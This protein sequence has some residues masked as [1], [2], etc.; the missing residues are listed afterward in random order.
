MLIPIV[1]QHFR[2]GQRPSLRGGARSW[3]SLDCELAAVHDTPVHC[4]GKLINQS[5]VA[6][7]FFSQRC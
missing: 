2:G 6:G 3:H 5:R 4:A 7:E 1:R